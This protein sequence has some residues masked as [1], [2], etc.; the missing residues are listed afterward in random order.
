[1]Q[2]GHKGSLWGQS[3]VSSQQLGKSQG[4]Q[5]Y[6]CSGMDPATSRGLEE[7][8]ES[9]GAQPQLTPS[10]PGETLSRGASPAHVLLTHFS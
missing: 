10:Q 7:A 1:M 4:P 2:R 3:T 6:N 5:S 9:D 8:P